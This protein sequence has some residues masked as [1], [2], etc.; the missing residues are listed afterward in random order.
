MA[1]SI[2]IEDVPINRFHQLLSVRSVAAGF[3]MAMY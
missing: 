3:W 1:T 2:S